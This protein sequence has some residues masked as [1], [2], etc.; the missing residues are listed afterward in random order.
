MQEN[1]LHSQTLF[2][3]QCKVNAATCRLYVERNDSTVDFW[4]CGIPVKENLNFSNSVNNT[5]LE[6]SEEPMST[7]TLHSEPP[8]VKQFYVNTFEGKNNIN[9]PTIGGFYVERFETMSHITITEN[10]TI[11]LHCMCNGFPPPSMRLLK[12]NINLEEKNSST[13]K[14]AIN[15]FRH[16]I[17]PVKC[18]HLG[19]YI[20]LASNAIGVTGKELYLDVLCPVRRLHNREVLSNSGNVA[21]S[22]MD[23]GVTFEFRAVANPIPDQSDASIPDYMMAVVIAGPIAVVFLAIIVVMCYKYK[24]RNTTGIVVIPMVDIASTVDVRQVVARHVPSRE[25]DDNVIY[26][27]INP[28]S[29]IRETPINEDGAT[30]SVATTTTPVRYES[31]MRTGSAE[32]PPYTELME[33]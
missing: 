4:K 23:G 29:L 18:H 13:A 9:Q 30:M 10:D 12:D 31:L 8:V 19:Q 1:H 17:A 5:F 26:H 3:C 25:R 27:E 15:S 28:Q 7:V 11:V 32:N 20:C 22:A 6:Y 21:I 14:N 33:K 24:R 2:V 16:V